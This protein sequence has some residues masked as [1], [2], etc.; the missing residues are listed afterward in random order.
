M[1]NFVAGQ[2]TATWNG[3]ALG[4]TAEGFRLSHS[5]FK[6]LI[7]GDLGAQTP[8]DGIYQ[9]REQFVAFR[10][11]EAAAAGAEELAEPYAFNAS[12]IDLGVIGSLDQQG[13]T[14]GGGSTPYAKALVLTAVVGTPARSAGPITI[15]FPAAILAE[16]FPVEVLLGPDLREIPV[17]MRCYPDMETGRFATST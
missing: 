3:K 6:R 11:I 12:A 17:R 14:V 10:L 2:Y 4:Q 7:T 1:S 5:F 9:G 15:T 13:N 8:Q 16:G